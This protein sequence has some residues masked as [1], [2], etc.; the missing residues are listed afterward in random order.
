MV[1]KMNTAVLFDMDGTILDTEP[2]YT[3]AEIRLFLE[4]GVT[5]P[6][7]DWSLY[8]GCSEDDFYTLSMKRYN[9][10][11]ARN[12]FIAKGRNYVRKEFES[13]LSFMP[14]FHSMIS[15]VK[16]K[17]KIGLVTASP[18]KHVNWLCTIIELN[19]I[20][21]HIICGGSTERN[22]PYPDPYIK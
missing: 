7:E 21:K 11:E 22:K 20:F 12:I 17:H 15:R 9:I 18:K 3:R 10:K 6:K 2:I 13:G 8:R 4:Y 5:I 19:K 14:G 16:E 1:F